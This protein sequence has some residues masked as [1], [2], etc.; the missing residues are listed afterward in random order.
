MI[1]KSSNM[2]GIYV[3]IPFCLKKC[4]YCDFY[5]ISEYHNNDLEKYT[6]RLIKNIENSAV[7]YNHMKFSTI[8]FGGGTPSLLDESQLERIIQAFKANFNF[9]TEN[10]TEISLEANPATLKA[11]KARS[12][13]KI[14][15]NRVSL[16]VQ[17]FYDKE[18]KI[19]GRI[20]NSRQAVD[21]INILKK[22]GFKNINL[23]LIFG[24]P[25]QSFKHWQENLRWALDF[26]PT[27][28]S[29]YLLQLDSGTRLAQRIKNGELQ[30]LDEELEADMYY[31]AVDYLEQND[32]K[33]YEISNFALPGYECRH[34]LIYWNGLPYI[35]L[36]SGAVSF[37]DNARYVLSDDVQDYLQGAENKKLLEKMSPQDLIID[38]IILKLRCREGLNLEDFC[39]RWGGNVLLPYKQVINECCDL[40]L[41]QLDNGYL[42]LSKKGLFLSNQVFTRLLQ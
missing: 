1:N 21:N 12:F 36:G 41:L 13:Y 40:D 18:L 15:I 35:G 42:R 14:G 28:I 7:Q 4:S 34:N 5:S 25:G 11:E 39:R 37:I 32:Y 31:Y 3:H 33:H 16:G 20:H 2:A 29:A 19:L 38:Q 26:E 17:S 30:Y 22:A 10:E 8:Y 9:N 23:D 6:L 27:H 24:I